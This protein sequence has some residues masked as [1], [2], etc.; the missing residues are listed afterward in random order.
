MQLSAIRTRT[1]IPAL[2]SSIG[3]WVVID[4]VCVRCLFFPTANIRERVIARKNDEAK[5]NRS[6][7]N[8]TV[9]R[10][11][12]EERRSNLLGVGLVSDDTFYAKWMATLRSP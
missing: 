2:V 8:I 4:F 6:C 10:H 1:A 9:V 5:P 12:E 11:C 7:H 3:S